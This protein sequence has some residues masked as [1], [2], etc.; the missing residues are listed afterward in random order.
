MT[1][2]HGKTGLKLLKMMDSG[3]GLALILAPFG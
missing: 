2:P 1:N 3:P